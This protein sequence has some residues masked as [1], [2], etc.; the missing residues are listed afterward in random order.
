MME[1]KLLK[2]A[3]EYK[4]RQQSIKFLDRDMCLRMMKEQPNDPRLRAVCYRH[5]KISVEDSKGE[6]DGEDDMDGDIFK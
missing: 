2:D 6:G 4:P 3:L 5:M 1:Q